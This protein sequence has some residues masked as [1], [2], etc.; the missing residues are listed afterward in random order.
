MKK[1]T[2]TLTDDLARRV[3]VAAAKEDKSLSRFVAGVLE[4]RC[5]SAADE[6]KTRITLEIP[7][8]ARF[9]WGRQSLV[10]RRTLYAEREDE[11]LRR[12][13]SDDFRDQRE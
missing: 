12:Y 7:G 3:H 10:G 2:V 1:V 11:L 13:K 4:E 8:W 5:Q 9:P 6:P